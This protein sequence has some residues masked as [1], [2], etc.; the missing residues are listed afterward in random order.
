MPDICPVFLTLRNSRKLCFK[1]GLPINYGNSSRFTFFP[2]G[3][4]FL[5]V[6]CV[7]KGMEEVPLPDKLE[8]DK[9][10][11]VP[12]TVLEAEIFRRGKQV[13]EARGKKRELAAILRVSIHKKQKHCI[14]FLYF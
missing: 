12:T 11:G 7:L 14:C 13:G 3:G 4:P 9:Y 1:K 8:Y 2:G 5:R 10:H 6:C